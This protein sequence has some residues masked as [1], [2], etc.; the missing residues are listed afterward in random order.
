[1]P[2]EIHALVQSAHDE[3][4]IIGSAVK[5]GMTGCFHHAIAKAD[6][7]YVAAQVGKL[8]QS[9]ER[10]MR[11]EHISLRAGEAP[12]SDGTFSNGFDVGVGCT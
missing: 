12:L 3:H 7:A 8:C 10:L 1:M 2:L 9:P 4:A 11:A 5:H 6:V